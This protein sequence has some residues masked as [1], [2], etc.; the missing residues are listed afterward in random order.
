MELVNSLKKWRQDLHQIPEIAYQEVKTT[1]YLKAELGKMGYQVHDL[2]E[3]GC[4]VYLDKH[5][6]K[7]IAFRS[8]IDALKINEEN[9]ITFKSKNSGY[10]HACGHD[11][12][13]AAML[14]FAARIKEQN[15]KYNILIIF[16]PAE[17]TSG[18]AVKVIE[19]GILRK[20]QVEAIF[21]MHVFPGLPEGVIGCRQGALM[22]ESGE[23]DIEIVGKSAHAGLPQDG[24]DSIVIAAN[25]IAT[26][27]GLVTRTTSPFEPVLVNLGKIRGGT[28]R[29]IVAA[30]TVLEGTVR[31]YNE[32]VFAKLI[33]QIKDLAK[34]YENTYG[35]KIK[36][37]CE[38]QNPPVLNDRK[39]YS[40][41]EKLTADMAYQELEQPVMLSEDFAHYQKN[42]PGIFFFLGIQTEKYR[43]GLHTPKLN[44]NEEV[45]MKAVD[46]YYKI[47]TEINLEDL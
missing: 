10:M 25:M 44:F 40:R 23:I 6:S 47:A 43:S 19:T 39:L 18:G 29:N 46:L 24:I 26:I 1:A 30:K 5:Q 45:L 13:M 35:C 33:K 28:V 27:Q 20:Y 11:G 14:G 31:A 37:W 41:F 34:G 7:T 42:L 16:Q 2:L 38:P 8:D 15:T 3:T 9:E 32:D 17:E 22:A 12:H 21:G 36:V 4:Y